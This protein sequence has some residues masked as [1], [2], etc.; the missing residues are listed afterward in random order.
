M[1]G[2]PSGDSQEKQSLCCLEHHGAGEG[3]EQEPSQTLSHIQNLN[4]GK[5][6]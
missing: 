4:S 6:F 5:N 3:Q 1:W 2:I